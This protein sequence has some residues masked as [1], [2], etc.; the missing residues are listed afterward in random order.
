MDFLD[1]AN[2][3]VIK[4]EVQSIDKTKKEIRL[5]GTGNMIKFDKMLVAWGAYKKRLNKDYTNAHYL[6][7]RFSHAKC[8]NEIIKADKI[9]ILGGTIDAYQIA[10]SIREYLNSIG[11]QKT[12]VVI[13]YEG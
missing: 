10:S 12:Q 13:M 11:Y 7:D 9:L 3:H 2:I 5:K 6:E 4:G 1:K 8:H